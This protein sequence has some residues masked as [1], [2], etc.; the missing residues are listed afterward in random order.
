MHTGILLMMALCAIIT[1][2]AQAGTGVA[3]QLHFEAFEFEGVGVRSATLSGSDAGWGESLASHNYA[4]I[5]IGLGSGGQY[6]GSTVFG[7]KTPVNESIF[8]WSNDPSVRSATIHW[9]TTGSNYNLGLE[10]SL[11]YWPGTPVNLS[12]TGGSENLIYLPMAD[13]HQPWGGWILAPM[14]QT[15]WDNG[16][17]IHVVANPVPEPGSLLAL[18]TGI[19]G[20][21]GFALRRK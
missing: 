20:L 14:F 10:D 4:G 19:S 1:L 3:W 12:M 13:F 17:A 16:Y 21:G 15:E 9:W 8:I 7:S 5:H 2:P 11:T 18:M 6:S